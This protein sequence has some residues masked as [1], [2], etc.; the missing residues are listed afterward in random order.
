MAAS[1]YN[2]V[3]VFLNNCCSGGI[4]NPVGGLSQAYLAN[5]VDFLNRAKAHGLFVVIVNADIPESGGYDALV[6]APAGFAYPN[7]LYMTPG[8]IA[9]SAKFWTDF[10]IGLATLKAPFD[11]I[12]GF[13]IQGEAHFDLGATP[14]SM[15]T[16]TVT[17]AN[18]KSYDLSDSSARQTLMDDNLVNFIDQVR[19]AVIKV[20]PTAPVFVSFYPSKSPNPTPFEDPIHQFIRPYPAICC[21]TA[22][23]IDLH[24]YL[25]GL[26]LPQLVQNFESSGLTVK[27]LVMFEYGTALNHALSAEA[28][29]AALQRWQSD[30]CS[31]GFTGWL[32]WNWDLSDATNPDTNY[33][34]ALSGGG[35]VDR[36]L[37]P[38]DRPSACQPGSYFDQD[39]AIGATVTAS[40]SLA[41]YGPAMAVDGSANT[42]WSAGAFAPQW[43]QIDL[44]APSIV[45][46]IRLTVSQF[47]NGPTVH[48][49]YVQSQG[50]AQPRLVS[51]FSGTT[52]DQQ[53][54]TWTASQPLVGVT[55]IRVATVASHSWVA[56]REIE[57][58]SGDTGR[59]AIS[60][61]VNGASFDAT[62]TPGSWVTIQ[63]T[64]LAASTRLWK[65]S[66]FK[67]AQLPTVLDGVRVSIDGAPASVYYISPTQL[68]V[69]APYP[70]HTGQAVAVTVARDNAQTAAS[71]Q[72]E[73]KTYDPALFAYIASSSLY[74][75]AVF[76]DGTVVGDPAKTAGTRGAR[77]G[78]HISLYGTGFGASPSGVV[79]NS[80]TALSNP[81]VVTVGG[82][83]ATMTYA[84]L[85]GAGLFQI[86]IV[87]PNLPVGDHPVA[88]QFQGASAATS[89]SIP[90]R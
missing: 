82:Q 90:I 9:A 14:L 65:T 29:A 19:G 66:D 1:G 49:L 63:G 22:D 84:G 55:S 11:A 77:P 52:Q 57:I 17:T 68:N 8:G 34:S 31:Y 15:T 33:W 32:L 71:A 62:I 47:P 3:R 7:I 6:G 79:I 45:T 81:V 48:D 64:G 53:V 70:I 73:S 54:L 21:S 26:T 56:W 16:G 58:L 83:P 24:A 36:A 89:P 80:H 72:V 85:V 78:N 69:Q 42:W 88:I 10:V 25:W 43:I 86:N 44:P 39:I 67:G 51:E 20:D 46:A 35:V 30:S 12:L 38:L 41:G 13:D 2:T 87:I 74:A 59:P 5:L 23:F 75:A 76:P 37:R 50:D 27:P 40:S 60:S 18:R 28:A 61:V 4:G